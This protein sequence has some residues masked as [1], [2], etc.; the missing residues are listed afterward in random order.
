MVQQ[1]HQGKRTRGKDGGWV[2]GSPPCG[3]GTCRFCNAKAKKFSKKMEN[4]SFPPVHHSNFDLEKRQ[5]QGFILL[6]GGRGWGFLL[7]LRMHTRLTAF[8]PSLFF[9][10]IFHLSISCRY[11]QIF[12]WVSALDRLCHRIMC[13]SN[14]FAISC[15]QIRAFLHHF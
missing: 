10:R 13:C 14:V 1:K 5:E 6:G 3:L 9:H 2:L 7:P 11:R 12:V 15:C 4:C 8:H